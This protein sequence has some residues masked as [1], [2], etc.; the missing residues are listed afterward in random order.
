MRLNVHVGHGKTG[1]SF[2]QSWWA[3]NADLLR[4]RHGIAYP[5]VAPLSG[6]SEAEGAL[7]RFSMGNGFILEEVLAAPDPPA[8]LRQLAAGLPPCGQLLFSCE[9]FVRS[10]PDHL[11]RLEG[12]A[13]AAGFEG[14]RLL[15][16]VRDPLEHAHSLY[17]EMVKAH[18][19]CGCVEEW[20]GIYNLHEAIEHFLAVQAAGEAIELTAINYSLAPH[21]LIEQARRW[22]E[23]PVESH[24][25]D[26]P[27][28]RVNRSLDREE[29]QALLALNRQLGSRASSVGMALVHELPDLAPR[30]C[31]AAESSQLAFIQRVR[32][33]VERIN[34]T[35]P[36]PQ[37]LRLR[38]LPRPEES[39]EDEIHLHPRQLEVIAAELLRLG[40]LES[41]EADSLATEATPHPP[42]NR[43]LARRAIVQIQQR[44]QRRMRRT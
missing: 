27:T 33:V 6:R 35:L 31:I 3:C 22:L 10:L 32:P 2:L 4:S 26:P 12:I 29:L 17:A 13:Q 41:V 5:L 15:L 7:G 42:S 1:S 25:A 30:A 38:S 23:V 11:S 44:L 43:T 40:R 9:R 34:T 21:R 8:L 28:A 39:H 20:L 16:F 18:G 37:A 24:F 36:P 14:L 19:F